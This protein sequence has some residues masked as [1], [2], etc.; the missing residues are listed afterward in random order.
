MFVSGGQAEDEGALVE[1][2]GVRADRLKAT[3][4]A[5]QDDGHLQPPRT[6]R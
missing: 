3:I 2:A 4:T 1:F 6:S 5:V